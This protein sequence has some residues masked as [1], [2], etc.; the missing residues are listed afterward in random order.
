MLLRQSVNA[1]ICKRPL[2]EPNSKDENWQTEGGLWFT[3]DK[4][5]CSSEKYRLT[6]AWNR[7]FMRDCAYA[8]ITFAKS[9][10]N[11]LTCCGHWTVLRMPEIRYFWFGFF[12]NK[13]CDA[14][15]AP[16]DVPFRSRW[17][18][19][20]WSN[21]ARDEK[22]DTSYVTLNRGWLTN[23][24]PNWHFGP[25]IFGYLH[26]RV[27]SRIRTGYETQTA[28]RSKFHEKCKSSMNNCPGG[29]LANCCAPC[30]GPI[31][32]THQSNISLLWQLAFAS[33]NWRTVP[34]A[35]ALSVSSNNGP[36]G[37][38]ARVAQHMN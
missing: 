6:G 32:A 11:G 14:D 20:H 36:I 30:P 27:P 21:C 19:T 38:C 18:I 17:M 33:I 3:G 5:F 4:L 34:C 35:T 12:S 8:I 25:G 2:P 26:H 24:E 23:E 10:V 9:R 31:Q 22:K 37:P 28:L 13:H 7:R 15:C 29:T 1:G 16:L